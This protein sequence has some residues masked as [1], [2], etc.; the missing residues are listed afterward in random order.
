MQDASMVPNLGIRVPNPRKHP[1]FLYLY[2]YTYIFIHE[3]ALRI[4]GCGAIRATL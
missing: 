2:V 4:L 1:A 3:F